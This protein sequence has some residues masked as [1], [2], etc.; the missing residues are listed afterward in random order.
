[1]NIDLRNVDIVRMAEDDGVQ[2][3]GNPNGT[4]C[5]PCPKC[6]GDDRF[7]VITNARAGVQLWRCRK[8]FGDQLL[9]AIRYLQHMRGLAEWRGIFDQLRAY[10]YSG[11]R[12]ESSSAQPIR[13][14]ISKPITREGVTIPDQLESPPSDE[15]QDSATIHALECMRRLWNPDGA[16]ALEYLRTKRML[17]D[18]TIRK[19]GLG[20]CDRTDKA[21][22]AWRGITIPRSYG[23]ALWSIN[24]R[25][26]EAN[27]ARKY[28]LRA[29][30]R[31]CAPLNGDA[32]ADPAIQNVIICE[33]EFDCMLCD[34]H[35][36]HGFAAITFGGKS[37]AP[38][39]EA[40]LLL[41]GKRCYCAFDCDDAGDAG[42]IAW[43]KI[44]K[45]VRIPVGKDITD[46][47][48]LGG[49]L[50]QWIASLNGDDSELFVQEAIRAAT[51]AG[52]VAIWRS[53]K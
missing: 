35:A 27:G 2:L 26:N 6:G 41:R 4:L 36:P 13:K 11:T 51:R 42:A 50:R 7:A 44:A 21:S 18:H 40:A 32:L 5:G 49:D 20:F 52:M 16:R 45:R 25:T 30:S 43:Q 17:A 9:D 47:V 37:I 23:G 34:Q 10:G 3:R 33:G 29:G 19:F 8:C 53:E 24:V 38:S 12:S 48:R 15:W 46:Y 31:T 28:L 1:M 22:S 14:Q 39:Y